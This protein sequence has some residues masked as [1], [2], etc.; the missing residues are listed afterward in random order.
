MGYFSYLH[1]LPFGVRRYIQPHPPPIDEEDDDGVT[2][3]NVVYSPDGGSVTLYLE[4]SVAV[5]N[6]QKRALS[7]ELAIAGHDYFEVAFYSQAGAAPDP[8]ND[9]V[10]RTSWELY[11]DAQITGIRGKTGPVPVNYFS[12]AVWEEEEYED[13]IGWTEDE[14]PQPITVTRIRTIP[15][16]NKGINTN[17]GA[18]ILF[19]GR[20]TDKTLLGVGKLTHINNGSGDIA[21]TTISP[22]TISVTFEVAALE[23]GLTS[24]NSA[25]N[26]FWTNFYGSNVSATNTRRD[27]ITM[28]GLTFDIFKLRDLNEGGS[29]I[30]SGQYHFR[31]NGADIDDYRRGIILAPG[32][33]VY[34]RKQPRYPTANGQFQYFP[35]VLDD[36]TVITSS[37]NLASEEGNPFRNP[38]NLMFDTNY[39]IPGSIFSLAFQIPVCPLFLDTKAGTWYIRASYDSYWLDLDPGINITQKG[40]GGALLFSTGTPSEVSA[41][42]IRVIAPPYKWLYSYHN[43][44]PLHAGNPNGSPDPTDPG[45]YPS[46]RHPVNRYFNVDGMVVALEEYNN[47]APGNFLRYLDNSELS[48]EIGMKTILPRRMVEGVNTAGDPLPVTVY[49][50]QTVKV[51]YFHKASMVNHESAFHIIVDNSD[52]RF[53]GIPNSGIPPNPAL[54][55]NQNQ[56]TGFPANTDYFPG[57]GIPMRNFLVINNN[58]VANNNLQ[59]WLNRRLNYVDNPS[60]KQVITFVIIF[61]STTGPP[62]GGI[63]YNF[64]NSQNMAP[65]NNSPNLIIMVAGR[66]TGSGNYYPQIQNAVHVGRGSGSLGEGVFN[67][68]TT[69]NAFYVGK[70]PFNDYLFGTQAETTPNFIDVG[71][72]SRFD[73]TVKEPGD[74]DYV[75]GRVFHKTYNFTLDAYGPTV[76]GGNN[77]GASAPTDPVSSGTGGKYFFRDFF[78]GR[79]YNVTVDPEITIFNRNWLF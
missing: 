51:I 2:Y 71:S 65:F 57:S 15:A 59:G 72:V 74:L 38:L 75:P 7:R 77:N 1:F 13:P 25:E 49:S 62:V 21:G 32:G 54:P 58:A 10:A 35:V 12:T 4:G 36:K 8:G 11:K 42:Q 28:N 63:H 73:Y 23:C 53:T 78:F 43:D 19:V 34:E 39:T 9:V 50:L 44:V 69:A 66:P 64:T 17:Q 24:N 16:L 76:L 67:N 33:G 3:T 40:A 14:P 5:P 27:T 31:T 26:S 6:R 30:T 45:G 48:F 29:N 55:I 20:K 37:N 60:A 46:D 18:A 56:T 22:A 47:G 61:D 41:Y 79:I 68:E 70:W 52:R